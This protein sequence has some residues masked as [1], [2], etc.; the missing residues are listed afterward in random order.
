MARAVYAV[1]PPHADADAA[2]SSDT[3]VA[4]QVPH[5]VAMVAELA[6]VVIA[7]AAAAPAAYQQSA[8]VQH[9][10]SRRIHSP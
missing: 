5:V 1:V 9:Q 10:L 8:S 4:W 7:V 6:N 3:R 2:D